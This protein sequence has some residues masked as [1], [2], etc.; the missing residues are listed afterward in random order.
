[1]LA[2]AKD[3]VEKMIAE[4]SGRKALL[5]DSE[6]LMMVSLVFSRTSLL[7]K[8][9]FL[10]GTI[11]NIPEEKLTHLK[12]IVLCRNTDRNVSLLCRELSEQPKFAQY[13]LCKL[14]LIFI[15]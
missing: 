10:I 15:N 3:Y 1:M 2:I 12:V 8:E 4:T 6:T 14:P 7:Q 9:V 5:M 11:D 13:N